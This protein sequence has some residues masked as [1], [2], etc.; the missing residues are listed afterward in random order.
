MASLSALGL[1]KHSVLHNMCSF[2]SCCEVSVSKQLTL[3][4]KERKRIRGKEGG[5]SKGFMTKRFPQGSHIH[6]YV[7]KQQG[8]SKTYTLFNGM[9]ECFRIVQASVYNNMLIYSCCANTYVVFVYMSLNYL[10]CIVTH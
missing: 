9:I 2:Y 7:H 8:R 6:T 5:G 3:S 10:P 4:H 1:C